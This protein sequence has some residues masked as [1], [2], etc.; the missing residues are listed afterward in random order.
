MTLEEAIR[1]ARGWTRNLT[2]REVDTSFDAVR[3]LLEHIELQDKRVERLVAR[4][5]ELILEVERLSLDLGIKDQ[6]FVLQEKGVEK[7]VDR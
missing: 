2:E 3:V 1:R 5:K 6:C 4:N 7:G